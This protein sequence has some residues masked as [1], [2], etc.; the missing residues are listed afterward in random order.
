MHSGKAF[1]TLKLKPDMLLTH[2]VNIE[3]GLNIG[4]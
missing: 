3:Q 4:I 1:K 2:S